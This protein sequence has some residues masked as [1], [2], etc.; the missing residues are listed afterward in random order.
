[1]NAQFRFGTSKVVVAIAGLFVTLAANSAHAA[2]VITYPVMTVAAPYY[3][4]TGSYG[5]A[6]P[7]APVYRPVATYPSA[8][9]YGNCPA[10]V[11][12]VVPTQTPVYP[13]SATYP[14]NGVPGH[15]PGGICYPTVNNCPNGV[16]PPTM[17]GAKVVYPANYYVTPKAVPATPVYYTTPKTAPKSVPVNTP[18]FYQSGTPKPTM[19]QPS[20]PTGTLKP[21]GGI[22]SGVDSPFYP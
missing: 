20:V 12:P 4:T 14:M 19:A 18:V 16:C 2:N 10:G 22:G 6:G 9:N 11:C 7:L 5:G 8:I 21:A 17:P 13:A 15:C 1:M 3:Y